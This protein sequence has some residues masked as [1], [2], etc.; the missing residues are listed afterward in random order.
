MTKTRDLLTPEEIDDVKRSALLA[1]QRQFTDRFLE[2]AFQHLEKEAIP[3][4]Y[5]AY[6]TEMGEMTLR[7]LL[8]RIHLYLIILKEDL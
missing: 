7:E 3:L 1:A 6:N 4:D 8:R 2:I 5:T